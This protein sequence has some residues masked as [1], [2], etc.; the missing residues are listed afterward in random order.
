MID[1]QI[2]DGELHALLDGELDPARQ[3]EV[4]AWL[5]ENPEAAGRVARYRAQNAGLHAL[6]DGVLHEELPP[7]IID[8]LA[9]RRRQWLP[10]G[11]AIAAGFALLLSGVVAGW[12]VRGEFPAGP[13]DAV[14][15]AAV[16]P[17][18]N[19]QVLMERATSAHMFSRDDDLRLA[20]ATDGGD[21]AQYIST[22]MGERVRVPQLS[23]L[24]YRLV[25]TRVLPD[26]GGPAAQFVFE[27]ADGGRVS[28]YL[29]SETARGV[30]ITYALSDDL[31][32]F[33]W[34]DS[35]HSYALVRELEDEN[36]RDALLTAA[37]A[38]YQQITE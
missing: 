30:D 22:R 37:Q 38:V 5:S 25:G 13:G 31:S 26:N 19:T 35:Q 17:P 3:A 34:N 1:R 18:I 21:M 24:G 8:A 27:D 36:G 12:V 23:D 32:M 9:G 29:R 15:V 16:T 11:A 20:S 4:E 7:V 6:Y 2:D 10:R 14:Q 33:Y 28:L